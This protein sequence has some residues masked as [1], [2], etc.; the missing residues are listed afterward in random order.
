VFKR[1][2]L[3]GSADFFQETSNAPEILAETEPEPLPAAIHPFPVRPVIQQQSRP[4]IQR[5]TVLYFEYQFTEPQVRALIDAVQKLK[6][7]HTLK[8]AAKLSME[9]FESMEALRQL[10]LEGL[11]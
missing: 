4:E 7:P 10:L 2:A 11:R 9:E 6:Y 8:N 1:A 3:S 5:E